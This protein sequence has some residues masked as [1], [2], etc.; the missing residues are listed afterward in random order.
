MKYVGENKKML[1]K[2]KRENVFG[3][4]VIAIILFIATCGFLLPTSIAI[5]RGLVKETKDYIIALNIS[6]LL[7]VLISH[8]LDIMFI[9]I[10]LAILWLIAFIYA[11]VSKNIIEKK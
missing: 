1:K 9:Y 2:H 5:A 3:D 11:C 4:H 8:S 7:G 10:M 6:V